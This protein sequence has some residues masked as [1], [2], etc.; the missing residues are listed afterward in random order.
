MLSPQSTMLTCAIISNQPRMFPMMWISW[1]I[2]LTWITY[3]KLWSCHF[4]EAWVC[5]DQS[6]LTHCCSHCQWSQSTFCYELNLFFLTWETVI[7]QGLT[8]TTL[9][10]WYRVKLELTSN[11]IFQY[12]FPFRGKRESLK[13]INKN[14]IFYF[15]STPVI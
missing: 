6:G 2:P 8:S 4:D 14:F 1:S 10:L 12:Y 3:W 5:Y 7:W 15:P 11:F 13:F 9:K